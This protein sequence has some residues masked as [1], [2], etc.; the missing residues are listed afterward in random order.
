MCIVLN[1]VNFDR[2][3]LSKCV[4]T[5]SIKKTLKHG[6]YRYMPVTLR[7]QSLKTEIIFMSI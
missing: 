7:L 2:N 3:R 4:Y 5:Y 1:Y 6:A